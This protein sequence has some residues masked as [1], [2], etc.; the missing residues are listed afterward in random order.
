ML[1]S[2]ETINLKQDQ[3]IQVNVRLLLY[4]IVDRC[5]MLLAML[6]VQ[7]HVLIWS[8]LRTYVFCLGRL[9]RVCLNHIRDK[10]DTYTP[11]YLN[12]AS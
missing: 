1:F 6:T 11:M 4:I 5:L 7:V 2:I 3:V 8:N 10:Y 9:V 12:L